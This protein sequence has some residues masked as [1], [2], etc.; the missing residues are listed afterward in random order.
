MNKTITYEYINCI[1]IIHTKSH[2]IQ[3]KVKANLLNYLEQKK[4]KYS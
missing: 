3:S 1:N 2:T 4:K